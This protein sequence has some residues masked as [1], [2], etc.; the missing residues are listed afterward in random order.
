MPL[1]SVCVLNVVGLTKELLTH[2]TGCLGKAMAGGRCY[3]LEEAF[4][5]VTCTAQATMLTGLDAT[6]HGIVGN[7]WYWRDL[8][9]VRFWLQSNRLIQGDPVYKVARRRAEE[10]GEQFTCAKL[11][12]WFNQGA[13]VDYSVTPKPY[14]GADGSKVFAIHGHPLDLPPRLEAAL[15]KFPFHAFWGPMSGIASSDWIARATAWV[16]EHLQPTLTLSYIPH[17]DYDLQRFGPTPEV[18][19]KALSELETAVEV[20]FDVCEKKGVVPIVV[21]E[22]GLGPVNRPV[23]V[24]R[25]LREAGFLVVR[26]GP[27]GETIETFLSDAFAVVDHQ[28]AH[29]YVR[30]PTKVADVVALLSSLP[31]VAH[32]LC[33][34]E[35]RARYHL[36]HPRA[37]DVVLLAQPDAYFAYHYWLDEQRAPDFARTVDIHRKPGYDPCELFFDPRIPFPKLRVAARLL[38]RKLG[39]RALLDVIPTDGSLVRG[40][41]GL[42][43]SSEEQRPVLLVPEG[44]I[45]FAPSHARDVHRAVL[46][47]LGLEP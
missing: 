23:Y 47:A 10:K 1:R 12:W 30:E 46:E 31:G 14:Y 7:G 15:G 36:N 6:D 24:N 34:P 28:I 27:F 29:V 43:A 39:F 11:F 25:V 44:A 5:A 42:Y 35:D 32:A 20:V 33:S 26:D 45:S 18:V 40:S 22:Y 8:G 41:H 3:P 16:L 21:S 17:L 13:P 4:P 9:E 38:Q 37:G 19:Q 2:C